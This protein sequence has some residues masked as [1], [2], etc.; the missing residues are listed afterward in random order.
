MLRTKVVDVGEG[1]VADVVGD[2]FYL[3]RCHLEVGPNAR[4]ERLGERVG[5]NLPHYADGA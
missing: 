3:V 1:E 4:Q 5:Q 2:S